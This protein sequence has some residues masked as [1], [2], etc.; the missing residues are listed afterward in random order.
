MVQTGPVHSERIHLRRSETAK[1]RFDRLETRALARDDALRCFAVLAVP[2]PLNKRPRPTMPSPGSP[3]WALDRSSLPDTAMPSA[4]LRPGRPAGGRPVCAGRD[5]GRRLPAEMG[6]RIAA[7][8]ETVAR[9]ALVADAATGAVTEA[10]RRFCAGFGYAPRTDDPMR[11]FL[12]PGP[13]VL[14]GRDSTAGVEFRDRLSGLA[15]P[16]PARRRAAPGG[17]SSRWRRSARC[18]QGRSRPAARRG[19]DSR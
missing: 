17:R 3:R 8:G 18:R 10:V 11:R 6:K 4:A 16:A 2:P 14:P 9:H 7:A 1:R 15:A 12:P 5:P 19:A 13:V